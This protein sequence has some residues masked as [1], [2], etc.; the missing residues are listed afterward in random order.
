MPNPGLL[1]FDS[2]PDEDW[3][4]HQII[5]GVWTVFPHISIADFDADG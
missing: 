3:P 4:L 1:E 5:G 2:E